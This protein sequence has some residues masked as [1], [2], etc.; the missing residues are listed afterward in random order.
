MV[1]S[2][3]KSINGGQGGIKGGNAKSGS[4]QTSANNIKID[5]SGLGSITFGGKAAST[6]VINTGLVVTLALFSVFM[7]SKK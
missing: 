1:H 3:L 4:R 6:G 2:G 7:M 5:Q